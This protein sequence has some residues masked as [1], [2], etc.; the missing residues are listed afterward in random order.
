VMKAADVAN[1]GTL[2]GN[3]VLEKWRSEQEMKLEFAVK[4]K[5]LETAL[6]G[7]GPSAPPSPIGVGGSKGAE[8]RPPSG[9]KPA[10][11]ETKASASGPRMTITES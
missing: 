6:V 2:P 8:G 1:W 5:E 3:T 11:M 9:N 10:H 7:Q 4:M